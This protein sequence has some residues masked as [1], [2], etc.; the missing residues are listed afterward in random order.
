MKT[1]TL[2]KKLAV[3]IAGAGV[4]ATAAMAVPIEIAT[5]PYTIQP[6]NNG[7]STIEAWVASAVSFY[8]AGYYLGSPLPTPSST[9]VAK[10]DQSGSAPSGFPTFGANTLSI[11]IPCIYDYLVLSWGG[12][13]GTTEYLYYLGND[14]GSSDTFIAPGQNGLSSYALFG[15]SSSTVPDGGSTMILMGLAGIGMFVLV[16]KQK[17]A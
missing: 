4:F 13:G 15:P 9:W 1:Q 6:R 10:V 11:T 12:R 16:R 17:T 14:I 2:T 7:E 5:S 3:L 8:N